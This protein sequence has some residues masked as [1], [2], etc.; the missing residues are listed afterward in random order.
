M[1]KRIK[2][3]VVNEITQRIGETDEM[4]VIDVSRLD[5][6][7]TNKF[8]LALQEKQISV[9]TV[10]NTLAIRALNGAGVT[11]LDTVLEGASTLVW[12]GKDIVALSKEIAKWVKDLGDIEIRGGTVEGE[13][14]SASDVVALS[15]SP[16][17]EELIGQIAGVMLSPGAQL[18]AALEAPA[19]LLA[20]QIEKI[21]DGDAGGESET[22][23]EGE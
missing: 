20:S 13:S 23:G 15:K 1:S 2:A 5:A 11:A 14:L 12:G 9:L 10:K 19:R 4:L 6:I 3:M 7:S 8:R 22:E 17:R 18:A 16:S 21:G